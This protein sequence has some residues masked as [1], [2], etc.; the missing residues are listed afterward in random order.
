M[1]TNFQISQRFFLRVLLTFFILVLMEAAK[2]G[3]IV[4]VAENLTYF[5]RSIIGFFSALNG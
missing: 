1:A 5:L 2:P 4:D 3:V